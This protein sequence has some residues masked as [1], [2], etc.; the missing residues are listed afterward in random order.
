MWIGL[1]RKQNEYNRIFNRNFPNE[2]TATK[3]FSFVASPELV[4][5]LAI[6]GILPFNPITDTLIMKEVKE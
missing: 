2:P 3:Y 5:A 1:S 6:A 4:T